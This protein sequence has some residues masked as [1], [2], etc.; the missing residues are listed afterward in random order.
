MIGPQ[1]AESGLSPWHRLLEHYTPDGALGRLLLA[2]VAGSI[3]GAALLAAIW[4]AAAS[5]LLWPLVAL[6]ST[7]VGLVGA[8]LALVALWPVYLSLIGNVESAS[9]YP[10]A[11]IAPPPTDAGTDPD[12]A[13]ALL[14]R[15]YAAGEL[16][17][18]EFERRL[19]D[20]LGA[21]AA[22]AAEA[23]AARTDGRADPNSERN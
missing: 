22:L 10:G 20:L 5:V 23:E 18:P 13:V 16:S 4:A 17:E 2:A 11:G 3:G 15:R 9:A 14:K 6:A 8:S 12:D 21:D 7:A 1:A 19:D